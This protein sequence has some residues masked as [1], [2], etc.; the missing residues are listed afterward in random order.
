V[1]ES[2]WIQIAV[3]LIGAVVPV[4]TRLISTRLAVAGSKREV[5]IEIE[6]VLMQAK[7]YGAEDDLATTKQID[8]LVYDTLYDVANIATVEGTSK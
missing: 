1:F 2:D 8:Y 6:P 7:R 3:T 5:V 4:A